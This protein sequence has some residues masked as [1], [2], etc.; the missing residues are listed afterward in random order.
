MKIGPTLFTPGLS[1][2]GTQRVGG[3]LDGSDQKIELMFTFTVLDFKKRRRALQ[4]CGN[5]S[6]AVSSAHGNIGKKTGR[7]ILR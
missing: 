1:T 6:A 5:G 2:N 3:S 7:I 4:T